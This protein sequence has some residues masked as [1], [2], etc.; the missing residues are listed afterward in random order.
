MIM[1]KLMPS[2]EMSNEIQSVVDFIQK[3]KTM[4][5]RRLFSISGLIKPVLTLASIFLDIFYNASADP[6]TEYLPG[7]VQ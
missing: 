6:H 7:H 3:V 2:F 5:H 4:D 1:V